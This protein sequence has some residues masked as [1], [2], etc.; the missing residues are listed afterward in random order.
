[1]SDTCP[2]SFRRINGTWDKICRH[3]RKAENIYLPE[4]I[5]RFGSE[6]TIRFIHDRASIYRCGLVQEW[7]DERPEVEL[8]WPEFI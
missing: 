5:E 1:M 2:G 6:V 3:P 8:V 7:F 4:A